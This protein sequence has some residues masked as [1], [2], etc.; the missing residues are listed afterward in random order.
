MEPGATSSQAVA[1]I[2]HLGGDNGDESRRNLQVPTLAEML[3][4]DP[5][6]LSRL[7]VALRNL[8][9]ATGLPGAEDMDI[10]ECMRRLDVLTEHVR[11][12]TDRDLVRFR[13]DPA[14]FN[15][16]RPCTENFFRIVTLITAL[17]H[18]GGLHYNPERTEGKGEDLPFD[19]KDMLINGLLSDQRIGTCNSIPV[20]IVAVGRRLGYPL[21]LSTTRHHVWARWDGS[22]ERFNIEASCPGGFSDYDD[23]HFRDTPFPM[24]QVDI[25][26]VPGRPSIVL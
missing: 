25:E 22:G 11:Q 12:T 21:Y 16:P 13:Q 26:E 1:G 6:A 4:M 14:Q 8:V 5:A 15:F 23:E 2:I 7:D 20:V 17:K 24:R 10:P 9:C 18:D 19:A 3:R